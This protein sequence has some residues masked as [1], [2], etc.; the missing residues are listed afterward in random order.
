MARLRALEPKGPDRPFRFELSLAGA[1]WF[2]E[3]YGVEPDGRPFDPARAFARLRAR[4]FPGLPSEPFDFEAALPGFDWPVLVMVGER[5][6]R[7]PPA[8]VEAFRRL[9]PRGAILRF[10]GTGHDLLG[11]R[12][13]AVLALEAACARGGL[14]AVQRAA[15]EGIRPPATAAAATAVRRAAEGYLAVARRLGRERAGQGGA[16]RDGG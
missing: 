2:R 14:D 16:G 7:T 9:L 4:S 3:V 1:I 10:P 11:R 12:T 8:A 6:T 5:D 15:D 13:D